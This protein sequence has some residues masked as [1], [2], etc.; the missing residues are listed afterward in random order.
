MNDAE[1]A[2]QIEI[3]FRSRGKAV[4]DALQNTRANGE[5]AYNLGKFVTG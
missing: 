1:R 5:E 3:A 2:G 4:C